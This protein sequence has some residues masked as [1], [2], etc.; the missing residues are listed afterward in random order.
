M[1]TLLQKA[2]DNFK[3]GNKTYSAD[4]VSKLEEA[5]ENW[6]TYT[7]C[8]TVSQHIETHPNEPLQVVRDRKIV[9]YL[10]SKLGL[11]LDYAAKLWCD[12]E[13]YEYE[14]RCSGEG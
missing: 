4:D 13:D 6:S 11:S 12:W 7:P 9:D 5:L 14:L 10:Y 2:F 1:Q 3:S 8:E